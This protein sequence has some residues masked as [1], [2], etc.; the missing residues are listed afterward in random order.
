[1]TG[2]PEDAATVAVVAPRQPTWDALAL[3]MAGCTACP[4]AG[5]R[6]RVVPGAC[7][8]QAQLLLVGEAPGRS[9]D[10]GG[11][12]FIGRSGR[13]L[14]ALLDDVG[15]VRNELAVVNTVKCRPPGNR[16][17]RRLETGTCRPWLDAQVDVVDPAV[18]LT[19]GGTALAWALGPGLRIGEVHGSVHNVAGRSVV[20]TYHPSAALR[21]GPSGPPAQA[22]RSDLAVVARLVGAG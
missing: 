21:F 6:Q 17:P 10:E 8:P 18:V 1:M 15:L 4:L 5:S 22:L 13:L 16:T 3:A 11:L 14:D 12:P 19:L 9:E 2:W 20:P 7:P